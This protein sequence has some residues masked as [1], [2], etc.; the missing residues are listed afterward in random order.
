MP[1]EP[2]LQPLVLRLGFLPVAHGTGDEFSH[3]IRLPALSPGHGTTPQSSIGD[4]PDT[5][6]DYRADSKAFCFAFLIQLQPLQTWGP[7]FIDDHTFLLS[8]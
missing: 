5:F 1:A 6:C 2:C 4:L 8:R 3:S 7:S